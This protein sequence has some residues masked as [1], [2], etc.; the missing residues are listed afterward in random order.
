MMDNFMDKLGDYNPQLFREIKGRIKPRNLLLTVT[1]SLVSQFLL[2][3]GFLAQLPSSPE[4]DKAFFNVSNRYCTGNNF[5]YTYPQCLL[6]NSGH[7]IINWQTWSVDL[8]VWVSIIFVFAL[9]VI[10]T[11]LLINDLANEERRDTLN[12]LRLTPQTPQAIFTG[13]MMGV[14]IL[15]YLAVAIAI[16]LHLWSGFAGNIPF[17]LILSFYGVLLAGCICYYSAGLL[18]ALIGSWLGGFQSWLA[19][20]TVL[21]FL[22]LSLNALFHVNS[23]FSASFIRFF[24]PCFFIPNLENI[25]I[26]KSGE[27]WQNFH[28][29]SINLG[30]NELALVIFAIINFAVLNYFIWQGLQRCF[31]DS[32]NTMLGKEK[33]YLFMSYFAIVTVGCTYTDRMAENL[34]YLLCLNFCAFLYLVAAITPHRQSLIDWA[35][36]RHINFKNNWHDGNNDLTQ[37]SVTKD[38]SPAILALTINAIIAI[39][40]ISSVLIVTNASLRDK[41]NGFIALG[42]AFSLA[43]LYVVIVQISLFMKTKHRVIASIFILGAVMILPLIVVA[44]LFHNP[45]K[46]TFLWLFSSLAPLFPLSMNS[47]RVLAEG[48]LAIVCHLAIAGFLRSKFLKNLY[49]AGES[50]TKAMMA[51]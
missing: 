29:L 20:G 38:K 41:G 27:T 4:P 14:P 36:Y 35:R 21:G 24:N 39:A 23:E 5:K 32:N 33:S 6:D 8:F 7:V 40:C 22:L 46:Y 12:F 47:S 50:Q 43:L 15:L 45:E 37:D 19:S 11:Y 49:K 42:L 26:Y 51:K 30:T 18:F 48:L 34:F 31:R 3:M 44:V 1:I 17:P 25:P 16:P 2:L 10:G 28:W 9:L 13:K